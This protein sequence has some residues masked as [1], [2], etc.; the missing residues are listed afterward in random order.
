M[1]AKGNESRLSQNHSSRTDM[2]S[3][4]Q[5]GNVGIYTLPPCATKRRITTNLKT[6][7][8]QNCQKTELYG[9]SRTREL[10][11][12]HSCKPV[13]GAEMGRCSGETA[14]QGGNWRTRVG[15]M[16]AGGPGK[17][18]AGEAGGPTFVCG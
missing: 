5:D 16:V 7:N 14:Q 13:G 2:W 4:G 3:P 1:M 17:T 11:K 15:K 6:K 18:A 8:N 10:K 9:S 12:K